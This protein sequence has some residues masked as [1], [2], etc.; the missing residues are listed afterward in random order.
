[1]ESGIPIGAKGGCQV[2]RFAHALLVAFAVCLGF[3]AAAQ[4]LVVS[5]TTI[6][7]DVVSRIAGEDVDVRTLLPIG[8]DPHTF[9]PTP[10][11]LVLLTQAA[12]VFA[13]GAELEASLEPILETA[14]APVVF[15][16]DGLDLLPIGDS[17][18]E[19]DHEASYDEDH[20]DD[21]E[22][23]HD[24]EHGDEHVHEHGAY[25]PHVWFDPA[26]VEAWTHIIERE[27]IALAPASAEGISTR[28]NA[29]RQELASLDG[30]IAETVASLPE[31]RRRLVS[32]HLVFGYFAARYG[33]EQAGAILPG[34]TTAADPSARE[35]ADVIDTIR[36]LDVSAIFV[37]E[38]VASALVEQ[39]ARDT[40]TRL[41]YL[42]T[43][44]LSEV[45]GPA[46]S[47]IDLV[48]YDVRAMVDA[49]MESP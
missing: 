11:D 32:D 15:L 24:E 44:S 4:V 38:T 49:L 30:W 48:R 35:L 3:A 26:Y 8:A 9:E 1:M 27:L 7:G 42:Y 43:G 23:A 39:V 33:F 14:S 22:E 46:A 17:G 45:G 28:A 34:G 19:E 40:G 12:L 47:Y 20:A 37:G 6:V 13:N 29:Y 18:R 31:D 21:H 36:A 25:D 41:V 2:R 10:Q 16:S 5:T